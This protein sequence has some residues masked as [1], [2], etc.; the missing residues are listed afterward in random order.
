MPLPQPGPCFDSPTT[1]LL[2]AEIDPPSGS[3]PFFSGR[4]RSAEQAGHCDLAASELTSF[5]G[6]GVGTR[7]AGAVFGSGHIILA[8]E[9][10]PRSET[11]GLLCRQADLRVSTGNVR[12]SQSFPCEIANYSGRHIMA[13]LTSWSRIGRSSLAREV[14]P[15]EFRGPDPPTLPRPGEDVGGRSPGRTATGLNPCGRE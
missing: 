9:N 1:D 8:T 13:R 11:D 15:P 3:H 10:S 12:R 7:L 14:H 2:P 4:S 5:S 6:M